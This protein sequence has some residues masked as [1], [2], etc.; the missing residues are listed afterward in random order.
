MPRLEAEMAMEYNNRNFVAILATLL[1]ILVVR[2]ES[3]CVRSATIVSGTNAPKGNLCSGQLIL[4]EN[5]HE[6]NNELWEHEITLGGGGVSV[7]TG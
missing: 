5:F 1:G 2:I 3:Q 7:Q 6:F 4:N